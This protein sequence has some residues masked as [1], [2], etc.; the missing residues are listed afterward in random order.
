MDENARKLLT[1]DKSDEDLSAI[2]N[3]EKEKVF[4]TNI[5]CNQEMLISYGLT[6]HAKAEVDNHPYCPQIKENCCTEEDAIK[7]KQLWNNQFRFVIERYYETTL[8]SLKYLLG[9]SNEAFLLARKFETSTVIECKN[10]AVDLISMNLNAKTTVNIYNELASSIQTMA[11]M[12]KGFYCILCNARTQEK[13]QDFWSSTNRLN[14]DR[15][16]MSKDFCEKLVEKTIQA[17]FYNIFYVKRYLENLVPLINCKTGSKDKIVMEIPIETQQQV[18]NC[19]YFRHRYFFFF[20]EKYCE[21]FHLTKASSVFDGD[22][23]ELRKFV[24]HLM[25]NRNEA[26]EYPNN[27]IL[28]DGVNFEEDILNFN[29]TEVFRDLVFFRPTTQQVVLDKFKTDVVYY[30]GMDPFISI[31]ENKFELTMINASYIPSALVSLVMILLFNL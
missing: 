22:I 27:N 12:R 21:N 15:I 25:N 28:T 29:F 16:Y 10:R 8:I 6:G 1:N 23:G 14:N 18:K 9:Y 30:G 19:Y 11:N 20:C 2:P 5:Q 7:A 13:L 24:L 31:D 3:T 4:E 17:S 26:F